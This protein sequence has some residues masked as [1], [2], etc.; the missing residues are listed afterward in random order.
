DN[1]PLSVGVVGSN[2][3]VLATREIVAAADLV[4]FIACRTGSTT[5]EHWRFPQLGTEIIHLDVD[6]AVIS[7]SYPTSI[8]LVGDA[9][10]G[11]EALIEAVQAQRQNATSEQCQTKHLEGSGLAMVAKARASKWKAFEALAQSDELPIRPERIID[12]LRQALP[13]DAIVCADPGTPC[14][15]VAAYFKLPKAG[16]YFVTNRAHGALGYAL[17]AAIGAWYAKPQQRCVALM[18]DGSFGFVAGEL[19]TVARCGAPILM[20]VLSNDAFGW[21]KASQR[22]SYGKRYFSV[23]FRPTDHA[24]IARAYGIDAFR[25]EDPQAL[26]PCLREALALNRPVLIDIRTQAL[27]EAA[28]PVSQWMG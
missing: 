22:A 25:V 27:E 13:D 15:Y 6:P 11:L 20:I 5:T 1:D 8:A 26:G 24:A 9:K 19:E 28:A 16:R 23:D 21:I 17:P 4:F 14:P 3:G 12:Q 10:L 7:S 18:G 2:G